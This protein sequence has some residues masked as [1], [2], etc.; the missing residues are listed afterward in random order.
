MKELIATIA[1][2]TILS[3]SNLSAS[4]FY[5][6]IQQTTYQAHTDEK[7]NSSNNFS[8][9][10]QIIQQSN[11]NKDFR[12]KVK[13]VLKNVYRNNQK[14]TNAMIQVFDKHL[15]KWL[16]EEPE[17]AFLILKRVFE[18]N[19]NIKLK[20]Y[21]FHLKKSKVRSINLLIQNNITIINNFIDYLQPKYIEAQEMKS[22][23]DWTSIY[24]DNNRKVLESLA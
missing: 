15:D 1:L 6:N 16:I 24:I 22:L 19:K 9:I 7:S 4:S 12:I 13:Q 3:A 14:Y 11:L 10:K 8:N 23:F 17:V 5:D 18:F 21:E 20:D 2:S